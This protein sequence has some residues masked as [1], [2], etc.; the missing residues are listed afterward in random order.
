MRILGA[1]VLTLGLALLLTGCETD[2]IPTTGSVTPV[3]LTL[4]AQ[5]KNCPIP[6]PDDAVPAKRHIT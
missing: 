5:K 6:R 1:T 3:P 4:S 2:P